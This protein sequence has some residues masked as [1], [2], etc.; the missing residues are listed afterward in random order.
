[1]KQAMKPVWVILFVLVGML[2]V[3]S[4]SQ[5]TGGGEDRIPWQHDLP[6]AQTA[7]TRESKPVLLYFTAS[8]CGPC[9]RMKETTWADERVATALTKYIPVKIDIDQQKDVALKYGVDGIPRVDVISPDGSH[10]VIMT[11]A[12]GPDEFLSLLGTK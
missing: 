10:K 5:F 8:W 4:I 11:G 3:V 7:S 6:A 1:M 9:K 12:A 2:A